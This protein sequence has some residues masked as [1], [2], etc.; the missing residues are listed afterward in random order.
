MKI[1]NPLKTSQKFLSCIPASPASAFE[2]NANMNSSKGIF[3]SDV[4]TNSGLVDVA[5]TCGHITAMSLIRRCSN[6]GVG[7]PD[8]D[9]RCWLNS[10]FIFFWGQK[11]KLEA[12]KYL[13]DY[14]TIK[15]CK[16]EAIMYLIIFRGLL[17]TIWNYRSGSKLPAKNLKRYNSIIY[18]DS[19][20]DEAYFLLWNFFH[21]HCK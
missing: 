9:P 4:A 21:V 19:K 15:N 20:Y 5:T 3:N 17:V 2:Y 1:P 8:S 6:G 10:D 13:V 12:I 11:F 18:F 16:V 14:L 7:L